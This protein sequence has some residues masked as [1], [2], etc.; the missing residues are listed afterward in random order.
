MNRTELAYRRTAADAP[1]GLGLL[2][3]LFDTLAGDLRRAADAQRENDIE[4]RCREVRHALLVLGHLEDW[5]KRG[6]DGILARKLIAF[7]SSLRRKLTEAEVRKSAEIFERQ[8]A[9]VLELRKY[10]Q[11]IES[12]TESS[13]PEILLPEFRIPAG[14]PDPQIE[15]GRGSWSA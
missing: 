11:Q 7:Y 1:G 8:M 6:E 13:G 14:Y 2:I 9:A 4:Q 5:V 3:G 10:W 15:S 12:R